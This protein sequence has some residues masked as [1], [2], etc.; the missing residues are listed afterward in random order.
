MFKGAK[1]LVPYFCLPM[2]VKACS[3]AENSSSRVQHPLLDKVRQCSAQPEQAALFFQHILNPV[4]HV[5]RQAIYHAWCAEAISRMCRTTNTSYPPDNA[6]E[7]FFRRG[8]D[9]CLVSSCGAFGGCFSGTSSVQQENRP[10]R[11]SRDNMFKH[12]RERLGKLLHIGQ[13]VEC[14]HVSRSTLGTK[15]PF[16]CMKAALTKKRRC[17]NTEELSGSVMVSPSDEPKSAAQ[18]LAQ[19]AAHDASLQPYLQLSKPNVAHAGRDIPLI[20]TAVSLTAIS[21]S[22]PLQDHPVAHGP[23]AQA[24]AHQPELYHGE[25]KQMPPPCVVSKV[26][27]Q[28]A[29]AVELDEHA[30]PQLTPDTHW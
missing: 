26:C 5:R 22:A 17:G 18:S 28:D 11:G 6:P 30:T 12:T 2:Q 13:K 4:P 14:E 9:R 10:Y 20:C 3:H 25:A 23:Q 1:W 16:S 8:R 27:K 21:A 19:S 29:N 15:G 7:D 24:H